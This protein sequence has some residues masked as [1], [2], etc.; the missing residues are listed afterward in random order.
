MSITVTEKAAKHIR[1][2]LAKKGG[3]GLRFGVR[4]VGC[5]GFA[6]TFDY[7][8]EV[9]AEDRLFQSNDVTVVVDRN[10]LEF[11]DG[12]VLDYV[13][14]GLNESFKVDNPKAKAMCGCGESFSIA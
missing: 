12:S 5:S 2:A 7:A 13:R 4:K 14:E 8:Q 6:Y 1:S 9:S 10:S 11:V 3:V